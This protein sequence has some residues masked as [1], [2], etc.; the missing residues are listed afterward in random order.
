MKEKS[1]N[2][3]RTESLL[4][5]L[6]PEALGELSDER[7]NSLLI[8]DVDCKNGKYD[9]IVYFDGSDYSD[10]EIKEIQKV[11]NKT[12][13]AIKSYCLNATGWYKC[14]NFKFLKDEQLENNK[15]LEE[16]FEKI[17]KD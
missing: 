16:L 11:L 7:I 5:E 3:K 17:K 13:G 4:K 8:T 14:P 10:K 6:I 9:A 2:L 12:N 15:R 1:I